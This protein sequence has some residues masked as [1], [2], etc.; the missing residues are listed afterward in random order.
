MFRYG[1]MYEQLSTIKKYPWL[2]KMKPFKIVGNTYF[3]GT[4]QASCHIIN[5][6]DGLIMIDP[7][8]TKTAYMVIDS[9][10]RLGF[11]PRD[12]K[13]IINTHWHGD[14]TEATAAFAD[15][16]GAKTLLG[17]DDIEKA[18][19]YFTPDIIVDDGDTLSLGNTTVRFVHTPGHTKGTISVFYQDTEGDITYRVG[20][21]GGAGLNTL[22]PSAFDF[23]GCRDAYFASLEC[24]KKE[25]V[26][27]FIGNHTWNN[28][29]L[30]KYEKLVDTGKNDFID[31]KVWSA[32]LDEYRR[33]LETIISKENGGL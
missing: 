22:V 1:K 27:V 23:E 24:L 9:I 33:R 15:L 12:I 31:S 25:P 5:T 26:D 17:R 32:F 2:G 20:M 29:T 28:D 14:H 11:D 30:G 19:P 21:F 18:K 10:Y 3:V 6:G 7:G 8:Y 4:Y 16:S 13:Y